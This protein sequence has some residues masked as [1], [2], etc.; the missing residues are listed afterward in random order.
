LEGRFSQQRTLGKQLT[1]SYYGGE[2]TLA[3]RFNLADSS[4][5]NLLMAY[6][7]DQLDLYSALAEITPAT[8]QELAEST[9]IKERH[10]R[11][12]LPGSE[13]CRLEVHYYTTRTDQTS[14]ETLPV[15][16]G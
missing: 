8:S 10:L 13:S 15:N 16:M 3:Q 9:G 2:R 11:E 7:G 14:T 1:V 5:Y 4:L 6:L 12:W